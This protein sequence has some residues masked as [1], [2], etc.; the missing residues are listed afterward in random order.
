M[1]K[2][3][4]RPIMK[5]KRQEMSAETA[6][7]KS[8]LICGIVSDSEIYKSAEFI[9]VYMALKNEVSVKYIADKAF[10]DGKRVCVPVTCGEDI[11][12]SEIYVGD[13]FVTGNFGIKE[14]KIKR[15]TN[16]ADLIFVPGLAF[17]EKGE[18]LGWGGGYYDRLTASATAVNV[19]ICYEMQ[20]RNDIET[21]SHDRK[22]DYIVTESGL[23]VC[24]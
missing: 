3:E 15:K 2:S 16:E 9:A 21:E 19:G 1:K 18:R 11:Y 8:R 5:M 23:I 7:E 4:L 20:I 6:A 13:E 24:E 14:P 10:A 22:M 12:L 17:S